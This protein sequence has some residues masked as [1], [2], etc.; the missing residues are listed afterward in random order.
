MPA[1]WPS[2]ECRCLP[3]AVSHILIVAS[4]ADKRLQSA[5][6]DL[7][8]GEHST[9][10]NWRSFA[11]QGRTAPQLLLSCGLSTPSFACIAHM[12]ASFSAVLLTGEFQLSALPLQICRVIAFGSCSSFHHGRTCGLCGQVR[13]DCLRSPSHR[14]FVADAVLVLPSR[15]WDWRYCENGMDGYKKL[16]GRSWQQVRQGNCSGGCFR[17]H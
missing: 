8:L 11:H 13:P 17:C 10:S 9:Y 15:A 4:A 5:P 14:S 7:V 1:R 3:V 6:T 2:S 16:H 12:P